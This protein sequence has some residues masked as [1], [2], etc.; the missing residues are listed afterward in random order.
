[1]SVVTSVPPFLSCRCHSAERPR[2]AELRRYPPGY[3]AESLLVTEVDD[4]GRLS[5]FTFFDP[6]DVDA[7][8]A[9]L[10][11]RSSAVSD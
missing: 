7:A 5:H 4:A 3:V 6:D 2:R 10:D 11:T 8:T 1:M 9:E